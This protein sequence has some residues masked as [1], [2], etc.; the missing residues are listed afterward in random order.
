MQFNK[1]KCKV[2]NLGCYSPHDGTGGELT[3]Q[4][5]GSQSRTWELC[6]TKSWTWVSGVPLQQRRLSASWDVLASI[7]SIGWGSDYSS[8]S[9]Q[10]CSVEDPKTGSGTRQT[11]TSGSMTSKQLS[12]CSG[13][14][15]H[16]IQRE[17]EGDVCPTLRKFSLVLCAGYSSLMGTS[18][19]VGVWLFSGI[20]QE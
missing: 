17:A 20:E 4:K 5:R 16:V 6:W 12:R 9:D 10:T 15:T 14:R 2:L 7:E 1:V 8:H 19:E 3:G 18:R 11:F 13:P